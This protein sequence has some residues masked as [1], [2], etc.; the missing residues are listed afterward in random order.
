MTK[1][2][3]EFARLVAGGERPMNAYKMAYNRADVDNVTASKHASRLMKKD[4]VVKRIEK[5]DAQLD[6]RAVMS[7]QAR[8]EWL[9][10]LV[11]GTK[12]GDECPANVAN[13]IRAIA[14]LNKMDGAYEPEKVEAKV[15]SRHFTALM[16]AITSGRI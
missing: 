1:E 14:E 2:A 11:R 3:K 9:S 10:E 16:D 12:V 7:K 13:G 15:E 4:E 5:A 6:R 8:M